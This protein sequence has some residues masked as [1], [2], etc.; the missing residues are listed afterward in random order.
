M[1][2]YRV[3]YVVKY[4][5]LTGFWEGLGDA[6]GGM[7]RFCGSVYYCCF[8]CRRRDFNGHKRLCAQIQAYNQKRQRTRAC[9]KLRAM[10]S[11]KK[12][13]KKIKKKKSTV[14]AGEEKKKKQKKKKKVRKKKRGSESPYRPY[15]AL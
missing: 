4:T 10:V 7:C 3:L 2:P 14:A 1:A 6:A 13:M 11:G 15:F 12:K 9:A 8:E 5:I